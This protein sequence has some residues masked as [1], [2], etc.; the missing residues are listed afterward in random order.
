MLLDWIHQTG[1]ESDDHHSPK[2]LHRLNT[3]LSLNNP[4]DHASLF[5]SNDSSKTI[6]LAFCQYYWT[7][8]YHS[9]S[10]EHDTSQFD[11]SKLT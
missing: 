5:D 4:I 9:L 3:T 2:Y 1:Y 6:H 11:W 8:Q 7:V 10:I